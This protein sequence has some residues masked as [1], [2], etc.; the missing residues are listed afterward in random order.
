MSLGKMAN[1]CNADILCRSGPARVERE[2][3][4]VNPP[5]RLQ[6]KA[7]AASGRLGLNPTLFLQLACLEGIYSRDSTA[8][9]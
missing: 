6:C 4:V 9:S 8:T 7:A 3:P 1:L 2:E 5:I